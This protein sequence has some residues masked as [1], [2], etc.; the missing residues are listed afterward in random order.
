MPPTIT[1][2]RPLI[3]CA[4]LARVA[5]ADEDCEGEECEDGGIYCFIW[6]VVVP[7][8]NLIMY[9]IVKTCLKHGRCMCITPR[10][11]VDVIVLNTVLFGI[12]V[13]AHL[14]SFE[15]GRHSPEWFFAPCLL[16]WVGIFIWEARSF[17]I[18]A[19]EREKHRVAWEALQA[20]EKMA[21][22]ER[23]RAAVLH[24]RGGSA[25]VFLRT[26][27]GANEP[28]AVELDDTIETLKLRVYGR[29]GTPPRNQRLVFGGTELSASVRPPLV[30]LTRKFEA[31]L[32]LSGTAVQVVDAACVQLGV[33]TSGL[34]LMQKAERAHEILF[35][36][37]VR[38]LR[39]I[40]IEQDSTIQLLIQETEEDALKITWTPFKCCGRAD[41]MPENTV[42]VADV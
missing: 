21:A 14:G 23:E 11:L 17:K 26:L 19:A 32:G 38:T 41:R 5:R 4:L 22:E 10:V 20:R 7:V 16:L 1:A 13:A 8:A 25:R 27:Q 9:F 24:A 40:G 28:I 2:T 18:V 36:N 15:N 39:D 6:D 35:P 12:C 33:K 31:E 29:D 30:E 34:S 3:L 42:V 37:A